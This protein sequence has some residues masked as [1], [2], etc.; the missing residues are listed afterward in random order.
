MSDSESVTTT[1]TAGPPKYQV[2]IPKEVRQGLDLEGERALLEINV[3]L[4]KILD[5]KGGGK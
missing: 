4:V 5:E 2:T 3:S 1:V